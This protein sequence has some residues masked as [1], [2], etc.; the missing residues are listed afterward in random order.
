MVRGQH[1]EGNAA[2]Q[3]IQRKPAG[4]A[5]NKA[6]IEEFVRGHSST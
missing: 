4:D 1:Y 3:I 5:Q 2:D 6:L